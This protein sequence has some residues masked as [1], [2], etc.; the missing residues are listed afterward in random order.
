M[1]KYCDTFDLAEEKEILNFI[2]LEEEEMKEEKI[3]VCCHNTL[4]WKGARGIRPLKLFPP[5]SLTIF[6]RL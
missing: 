3:V 4:E 5:R 6:G 2:L 1:A